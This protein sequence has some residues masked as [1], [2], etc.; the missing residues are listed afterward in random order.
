LRWWRERG[1]EARE[2]AD[3]FPA[4][5]FSGGRFHRRETKF[6]FSGH[7]ASFS[8]FLF[9]FLSF[10]EKEERRNHQLEKRKSRRKN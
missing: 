7:D 2:V 3:D 5:G 9:S 8:L 4:D 10:F 1:G 6:V